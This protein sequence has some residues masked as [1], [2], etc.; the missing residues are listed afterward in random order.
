GKV[1]AET[2]AGLNN[3]VDVTFIPTVV[4][5]RPPIATAGLSEEEAKEAEYEVVVSQFSVS[6]NGF[7]MITNEKAGIC[8]LVKDADTD[9]LLGVHLMEDGGIE[10]ISTGITALEMAAKEEDVKFPF[11]PHPSYNEALLEAI[12]GFSGTAIHMAPAKT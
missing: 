3:E 2:I 12:E 11:Y 8:K 9:M 5:S 1:A 7:A 6:G 4:H 10:Q